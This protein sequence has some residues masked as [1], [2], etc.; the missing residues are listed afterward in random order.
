MAAQAGVRAAEAVRSAKCFWM[1][2]ENTAVGFAAE[3]GVRG[4][5]ASGGEDGTENFAA[6]AGRLRGAG[7]C[8][9]MQRLRCLFDI[10]VEIL[11]SWANKS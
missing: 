6:G 4:Q 11:T 3:L 10:Q 5:R 7:S 2:F 9:D 1:C 8:L